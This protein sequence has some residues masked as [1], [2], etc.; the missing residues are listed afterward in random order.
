MKINT[1]LLTAE[2]IKK[3]LVEYGI[4]EPLSIMEKAIQVKTSVV[5]PESQLPRPM[6]DALEVGACK[7]LKLTSLSAAGTTLFLLSHLWMIP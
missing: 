6:A 3:E 7:K 4:K 2:N 1:N 5:I